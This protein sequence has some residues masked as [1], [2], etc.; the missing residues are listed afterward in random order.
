MNKITAV[1]LGVIA[2]TQAG[3]V[4]VQKTDTSEVDLYGRVYAGHVFGDAGNIQA[5]KGVSSYIRFGTKA[6][7]MV[8]R[9]YSVVG[10][11][12][13][14]VYLSDAEKT[15]GS[16]GADAGNFRTRLAY[17]GFKT[18]YGTVTFG[19]QYGALT[20][21]TDY[22][23]VG[24]G[25]PYGG[26][27]LGTGTDT[28][29]TDRGGS[30]LK[31]SGGWYGFNLEAQVQLRNNASTSGGDDE[32]SY[33]IAASYSVLDTGLEVGV[34]YNIG[35]RPNDGN[36]AKI[37]VAGAKYEIMGL[38]AGLTF[39]RGTNFAA[40]NTGTSTTEITGHT[41]Y[42]VALGYDFGNGW[43]VMGLYNVLEFENIGPLVAGATTD[44]ADKWKKQDHIVLGAQYKFTDNFMVI[45][46]YRINNANNL[47]K[48]ITGSKEYKNDY[49]FALKYVF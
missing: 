39:A 23:D 15:L 46:E 26:F 44:T 28:F 7:A 43:Q 14:Q 49:T 45:G 30:I 6:Q 37:M 42:E 35:K 13:A 12:E 2:A 19:R 8:T 11:Y 18:D 1:A 48:N 36:D 33:G 40:T 17:A 16:A 5:D 25:D 38:Y 27:G 9:D 22:T 47:P 3:A 10:R 29:G 4:V 24:L 31:Y 34:G 21:V 32:K 41:G 20:L